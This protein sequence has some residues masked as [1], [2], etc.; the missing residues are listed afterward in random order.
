MRRFLSRVAKAFIILTILTIILVLY[1]RRVTGIIMPY[2]IVTVSTLLSSFF[3]ALA[4]TVFKSEKGIPVVNAV[5]GYLLIIP[6]LFI[7]RATY[8][9]YLFQLSYL[10]YIIMAVILIIYGIALLVA[11]KKYKQ[12]VDELNRLLL[13]KQE[14]DDFDE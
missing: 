3:A 6:I 2:N 10:I 5:L 9:N 8:N 12:E 7:I 14:D 4:R 13:D 11:K 1:I